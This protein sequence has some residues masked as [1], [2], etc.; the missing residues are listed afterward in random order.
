MILRSQSLTD[1]EKYRLLASC[2]I[3]R[4]IAW[5]TSVSPDKII[6]AAPFSF[7]NA[8]T[9][10]PP[11]V[12]ISI[13]RRDGKHKDTA[14]NI[15]SGKEFVVNIVN[16]ALAEHMNATSASFPETVSEIERAGLHLSPSETIATPRIAGCPVHLEC[17]LTHAIEIGSGPTDVLFGEVMVFHVADEVLKNQRI[18]PS[19]LRAVGRLSGSD[20]CR[21]T[22]TFEM[23]RPG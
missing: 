17:T 10:E 6:N 9:G 12:M 5:V 16:E 11:T 8:I 15:L 1:A 3:P 13:S 23:K 20:Y 19:L 21:T 22:E 2:V 14:R 7:F 18:D 4:P